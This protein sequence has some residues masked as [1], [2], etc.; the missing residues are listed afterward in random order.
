MGVDIRGWVEVRQDWGTGPQWCG[1]IRVEDWIGRAY[2]MFGSLFG[3]QGYG[4]RPV[5][6]DRG[7]PRD[8]SFQVEADGGT[9][10]NDVVFGATWVSWSELAGVDW[11]E[12][13]ERAGALDTSIGPQT[14]GEMLDERWAVLFQMMEAMARVL[15]DDCVRLVVWFA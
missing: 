12:R 6:A 4:F 3:V 14:R 5:G 10:D 8:R 9:P 1:V 7:F 2:G 15:G 11:E 13:E